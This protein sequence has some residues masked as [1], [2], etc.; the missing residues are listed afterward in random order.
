VF[1]ALLLDFFTF[2]LI[3]FEFTDNRQEHIKRLWILHTILYTY[4]YVMYRKDR[5]SLYQY[6]ETLCCY[7]Y[8]TY[9]EYATKIKKSFYN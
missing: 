5:Q 9:L 4:E 2:E 7:I 6:F 1:R 8:N 3:Y